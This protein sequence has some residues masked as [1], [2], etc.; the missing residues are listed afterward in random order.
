MKEPDKLTE[1]IYNAYQNAGGPLHYQQ[2]AIQAYGSLG[3]DYSSMGIPVEDRFKL[4]RKVYRKIRNH[5]EIFE[6]VSPGIYRLRQQFAQASPESY[7]EG[8]VQESI[9]QEL[10]VQRPPIMTLPLRA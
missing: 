1:E 8:P 5:P 9:P 6:R 2:A 4:F 7:P 3:V 10:P